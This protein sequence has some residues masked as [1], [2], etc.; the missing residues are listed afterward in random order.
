[1]EKTSVP[2]LAD[3]ICDLRTRKIKRAFFTQINTL[4]DWSAID[5]LI[6][7]HYKKEKAQ[8][9]IPVIEAFNYLK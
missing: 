9:G 7:Q 8:L 5:Q 6:K 3:S 2:T 4:L 1:M